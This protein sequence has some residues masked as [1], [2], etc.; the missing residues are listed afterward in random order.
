MLLPFTP[1][2][3]GDNFPEMD[4]F[5]VLLIILAAIFDAVGVFCLFAIP[6]I[7]LIPCIVFYVVH[8]NNKSFD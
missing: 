2:L 1:I 6:V 8:R 7:V 4:P 3:A 5:T